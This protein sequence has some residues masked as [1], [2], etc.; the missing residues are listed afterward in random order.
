MNAQRAIEF[1]G[2]D[3]LLDDIDPEWLDRYVEWLVKRG[4][5]NGGI[6]R[7]LA[8]LSTMYTVAMDRGGAVRRPKMPRQKEGQGRVRWLTDEEEQKMS[9]YLIQWGDFE[10][11]QVVRVLLDT[12]LR[13]GELWSLEARDLQGTRFTV[14]VN[15][16]DHP[17][18]LPM[19]ERV[20]K[21]MEARLRVT[22]PGHKLFPYDNAWL[23]QKWLRLR[24]VMGMDEDPQFVPHMLRH[25]C[26]SRLAQRG[27]TIPVLQQWLGHKTI[28][29]TMRYAHL[30]PA[31]LEDAARLLE[32]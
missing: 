26:A 1:F 20:Q 5:S 19:T 22:E 15:K 7:K 8:A 21:I 2:A 4:N 18:T 32:A 10:T 12:G 13:L 17:R 11:L 28:T 30:A 31:H 23:R 3:A 9:A 6:N 27:A 16:A 24:S 29:M 25:T 14:W